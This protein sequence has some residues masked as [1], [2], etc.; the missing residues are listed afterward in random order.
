MV[1]VRPMLI[2]LARPPAAP[3]A[4]GSRPR[5]RGGSS[6]RFGGRNRGGRER[7]TQSF[8]PRFRGSACSLI[9]LEGGKKLK[10]KQVHRR[11]WRQT[12]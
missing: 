9:K 1:T 3:V 7:R 11:I 8:R 12:F 10:S 6:P 2:D 4:L 5:P